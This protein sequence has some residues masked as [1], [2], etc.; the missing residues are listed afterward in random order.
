[1]TARGYVRLDGP[2]KLTGA[3][4]YAADTPTDGALVAT[5]VC[6]T[7]AT[8][9]IA[10]LDTEAAAAAPGVVAVLDHTRMPRLGALPSPPLGHSVIPMQDDVIHYEGQP[11]AV[12]LAETLPQAQYAAGLVIATYTDTGAP[13]VF[14]QVDEVIPRGGHVLGDTDLATGDVDAGLAMADVTVTGTYTTADRHHSP[15]EPSATLAAWDGDQLTLHSSVQSV[16]VVQEAMAQLFGLPVEHVRVVCPFTGGGFGAKGYIWP[17]QPLAAAAAGVTGRPVKLVLTRAQMFAL[18]GHQPAT[19]QTVSLGARADGR[20]TAV[21]HHSVNPSSCVDDYLEYT[22]G[23]TTWLYDS[24]AIETSTRIQ[25]LNRSNGTPMRAPHEGPGVFALESAMDEL[26]HQLR[27]DPVELRLRNEPRV[28][29]VTGVPFSSRKLVE[30]LREG[31][32]R[33]GWSRRNPAPRS[34][35]D[36]HDLIGWGVAV[37]TMDTFRGPSAAKIRLDSSGRV[38]VETGMQE[39]GTGLPAMVAAVAAEALGCDPDVVEVRHGDSA[40]PPH[41]GTFGSRSTICLGAAVDAAAREV[42]DKLGGQ[43][44]QLLAGLLAEAGLTEIE[45]EGRWEPEDSTDVVGRRADYSMHTYGSVF[46]EVRVDEDLGLVRMPRAV[47]TY[48]AGRIINPLAAHS[49]MTG[50]IIWGYGQALLE[51]SDFEPRHERFLAKNL[52]GYI[53][54]VN[55]DIAGIDVSFVPDDDRY[56]GPLGAKGIGELGAVGVSAAIANAVFHATGKRIR[57]LPI[58]IRKL[59]TTD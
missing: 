6:S 13:R 35:R 49:Q 26:A 33:F 25:R 2:A 50:G 20:L 28:D 3:A 48:A 53:V 18:C 19:R 31:A 56:A 36:G 14:G 10:S 11:I 21:R 41:S 42:L 52:A 40:L 55:A 57:D 27:I 51:R 5:L 37:A 7:V 8:G 58:T 16:V 32:R 47:G 46:V 59:F 30:C 15:I 45:A 24:P 9:R 17:P 34:M 29:P 12:V 23:A 22:T 43:P 4:R 39:I 1:M 54:P 38:V 44:G